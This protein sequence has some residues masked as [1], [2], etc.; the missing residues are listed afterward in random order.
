[1]NPDKA[2]R[3]NTDEPDH[4]PTPAETRIVDDFE[5]T[6]DN[7]LD[8][9]VNAL[10]NDKKTNLS[11]ETNNTIQSTLAHMNQ[12]EIRSLALGAGRGYVH[13][14]IGAYNQLGIS[15]D[16]VELR[17]RTA[18]F[19]NTYTTLAINEGVTIIN[20]EKNPWISR[21]QEE[22]RKSIMDIINDGIRQGKY[23][24]DKQR[25]GYKEGTIG[26]DLQQYFDDRKSHATMVARTETGRVMNYGRLD[27]FGSRGVTQVV[28]LDGDGANPCDIC[29]ILNGST[30]DIDFAMTHE[31]EHPNCVRSFKPVKPKGG[32]NL[33]SD[34]NLFKRDI[35]ISGYVL[36]V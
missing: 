4:E 9:L 26:Y 7:A 23:P 20:G 12:A 18:D 30:W 11:A 36:K 1:M 8:M 17:N 16:M 5:K 13:G 29:N 35:A 33:N 32:Y 22:Q 10:K 27:T 2:Q 28:V 15:P 19:M 31:L 25:D 14:S 24:G 34:V 21:F 3:T 6:Y